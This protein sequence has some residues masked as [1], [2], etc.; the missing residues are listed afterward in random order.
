MRHRAVGDRSAKLTKPATNKHS[1]TIHEFT[2]SRLA[3]SGM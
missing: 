3:K 2:L 1:A